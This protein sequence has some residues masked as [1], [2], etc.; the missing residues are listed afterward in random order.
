MT[1]TISTTRD[2]AQWLDGIELLATL[3]YPAPMLMPRLLRAIR[4]RIDADFGGVGWVEGDHLRPTAYW[5]ERMTEATY[6][7]F[8]RNLDAFF[9][10]YPLRAQLQ[11]DGEAIRAL[12]HTKEFEQYWYLNE[13]LLP[14]GVRWAMGVP[15]LSESGVCS[16]F[17]YVFREARRGH[18]SDQEQMRLRLVRDRMRALAS[19]AA[20][21]NVK[22]SL[23]LANM[24]T[25]QFDRNGAMVARSE[26][27]A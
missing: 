6:R 19:K 13:I 14:L 22:P 27:A 8:I 23:R 9:D 10:E 20:N 18:Y 25:L 7:A 4:T 21:A 12:Q 2:D 11:S 3:P 15:V 1:E 26:Q 5:S 17:L 16:G 24:A